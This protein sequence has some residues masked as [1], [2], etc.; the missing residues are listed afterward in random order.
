[1]N[2]LCG[3]LRK[4]RPVGPGRILHRLQKDVACTTN[5]AIALLIAEF[6]DDEQQVDQIAASTKFFVASIRVTV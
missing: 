1:M 6:I 5:V 2:S 4:L 3:H